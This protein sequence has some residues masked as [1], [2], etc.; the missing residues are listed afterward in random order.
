MAEAEKLTAEILAEADAHAA[1]LKAE[2]KAEA[3]KIAAAARSEAQAA[4]ERILAG[5]KARADETA[6]R[7]LTIAE[8]EGRKEILAAKQKHIEAAFA[9]A[10]AKLAGLDT[11]AYWQII[12]P[13]LLKSVET[14]NETVY[15]SAHDAGRITPAMI[16][17]IN[18]ALRA[19]GKPGNLTLAAEPVATDGGFI[20]S[21]GATKLNSS[22]ATVVKMLRDELEPEVA[23]ILFR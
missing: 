2:A 17:E 15:I 19:A 6:R 18:E 22:F 1:A 12:K 3:E 13:M 11:A 14:G 9:G 20:L 5:A 10:L 16:E 21:T 23:E 8:L 4:R 7:V